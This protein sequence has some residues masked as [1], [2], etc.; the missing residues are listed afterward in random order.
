MAIKYYVMPDEKKIV[1][2][3]SGTSEDALKKMRKLFSGKGFLEGCTFDKKY[4]MPKSFRAVACLNEEDEWDEEEG[5]KV[6]K[7]K[8]MRKYYESYDSKFSMLMDDLNSLM[9]NVSDYNKKI[10][11]GGSKNE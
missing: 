11:I 2:T 1:A 4:L 3:L 7:D 8:L 9:N 5:K 10:F 6:A